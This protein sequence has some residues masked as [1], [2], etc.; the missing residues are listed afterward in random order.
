MALWPQSKR[1]ALIL[2]R[3]VAFLF[4]VLITAPV[5]AAILRFAPRCEL[6][7]SAGATIKVP[8]KKQLSVGHV[9]MGGCP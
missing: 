8:S 4:I 2:E 3:A 5:V 9:L 7:R 1:R 6:D